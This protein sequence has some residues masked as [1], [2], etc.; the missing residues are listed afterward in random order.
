V[1]LHVVGG[2][3]FEC[4]AGLDGAFVDVECEQGCVFELA[5]GPLVGVR[6]EVD[7]IRRDDFIGEVGVEWG[8]VCYFVVRDEEIVFGERIVKP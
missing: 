1:E 5:E 2:G 8:D 6:D 7:G 4:E 3:V